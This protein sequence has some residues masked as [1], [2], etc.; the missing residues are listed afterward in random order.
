MECLNCGNYV[1]KVYVNDKGT[2]CF[3]CA[4]CA[5]AWELGHWYGQ[6][7]PEITLARIEES[8]E[9]DDTDPDEPFDNQLPQLFSQPLP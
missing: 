1:T 4:S 8:N 6:N 5:D 2:L 3:L 9:T 7:Q